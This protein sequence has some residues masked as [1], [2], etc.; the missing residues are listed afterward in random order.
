MRL[1]NILYTQV[2]PWIWGSQKS[3][4]VLVKKQSYT[5]RTSGVGSGVHI[6]NELSSGPRAVALGIV[7]LQNEPLRKG[8]QLLKKIPSG[9][10]FLPC[11]SPLSVRG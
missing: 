8:F 6:E 10:N 11:T 4:G 2:T 5:V 7:L 1:V 9:N 3:P